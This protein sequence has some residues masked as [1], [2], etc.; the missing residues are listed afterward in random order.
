MSSSILSLLWWVAIGLMF[1]WM[2]SRGGCGMA[3]G[4]A[5]GRESDR[6][7]GHAGHRKPIDP[8]CGMEIDPA[9]AAGTRVAD[10]ETYFFCSQTCLDAFENNP[11]MYAHHRDEHAGHRHH[12]A[13]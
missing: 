1:F 7:N 6:A 12:A 3:M 10:G 8:V 4:H 13:C 9:T 2:M 5:H 11:A